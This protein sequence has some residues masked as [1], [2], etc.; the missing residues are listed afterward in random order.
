MDRESGM[1][2][3]TIVVVA[4]VAAAL[5]VIVAYQAGVS[6]G[7][8]LQPV[9]AV[10]PAAPGAAQPAP[11]PPYPYYAYGYYRPW[12]FGLFGPLL[13]IFFLM[14]VLRAF[15][16]GLCGWGWRRRWRYSGYPDDGPSRFDQWHRRAHDR[17]RDDDAPP[18]P[19]SV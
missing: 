13:T 5:L 1:R 3:W 7:I 8:A 12:R 2:R 14:F 15:F 9:P 6:H 10:S 4:V 16:G 19:T 11:P 17:M 18:A